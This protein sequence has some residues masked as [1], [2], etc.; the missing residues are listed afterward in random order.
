MKHTAKTKQ[1]V[2][3]LLAGGLLSAHAMAANLADDYVKI[4]PRTT[5]DT[6]AAV[7]GDYAVAV[8]INSNAKGLSAL[9]FGSHAKTEG[10]S[11]ISIGSLATSNGTRA[12]S[13]GGQSNATGYNA[14]AVG[15]TTGAT[16][17]GA[18][19]VGSGA[20]ATAGSAIALGANAQASATSATALG[21][22]ANAS[23][24]NATALGRGANASGGAAVALGS[25]AAASGGVSVATGANAK[26][27]GLGSVASGM[28]SNASAGASVALGRGASATEDFS[29]ALGALSTTQAA[30]G[31]NEATVNGVTYSGFAGNAPV[32]TV[33]VGSAGQERTVTN[34]AAGRVTAS[35][36][37]AINGSQLYLLTNDL[38]KRLNTEIKAGDNVVVNPSTDDDD[39]PVYTISANSS[40][41]RSGSEYVTVTPTTATGANGA[42]DTTYTIDLSDRAKDAL[43]THIN[44]DDRLDNID[45]RISGFND[46]MNDM[47]KDLR[48]GIAGAT[49]IAFLQ[50]PNEAGKSIVSAAVGG[51]RDQQAL[52]IGYA[53]NS[54]NNKWSIKA[55]LGVNTQKD[56]N[57]GGSVGYQW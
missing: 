15:A 54:D 43:N 35:S 42:T 19:A 17:G 27:S 20:K 49:A 50:R 2:S 23:S 3:V 21:M 7:D 1:L 22:N 10:G 41:S 32:A 38:S 34:V 12:T 11:A 33:S 36:T 46:R 40:T 24:G 28:Q 4:Q 30:V 57:W 31:T 48:A 6:Q 5:T 9:S 13:I 45:N 39:N 52:A 18:T 25:G 26:A 53:R 55:G 29:V 16:A 51:F 44:I 8:G 47:E 14:T 37:D 56:I